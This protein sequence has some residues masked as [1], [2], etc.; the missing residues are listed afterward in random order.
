MRLM[1]V[2]VRYLDYEESASLGNV[3]LGNGTVVALKGKVSIHLSTTIIQIYKCMSQT[4]QRESVQCSVNP[5]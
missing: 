3:R 4:W 2:R 5:G 1:S